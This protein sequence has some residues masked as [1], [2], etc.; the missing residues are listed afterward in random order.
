[1]TDDYLNELEQF[2][3]EFADEYEI[4]QQESPFPIAEKL[5]QFLLQQAILPAHSFLDLAGGSG[6]Y[7]A[8]FQDT[9]EH[10]TLV[11]ISNEML[12]IAKTKLQDSDAA[13]VH[14]DQERFFQSATE[15]FDVVFTAMNPVLL[16]KE[17]LLA[18]TAQSHRW[19]LI[20]RLVQQTDNIF[21]PYEETDTKPNLM[22]NYK[23][24]L[25][26]SG[27]SYNSQDFTF[28]YSEEV[29]RDFFEA[30]FEKELSLK[31]INQIVE[32]I[33]GLSETQLN[34]QTVCYQLIY[35]LVPDSPLVKN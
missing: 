33:F 11:D 22:E 28:T 31:K 2:W 6:R 1:M 21:S 16:T 4:I 10:Y 27:I 13:F 34:F 19:C 29:T 7:L 15:T 25:K 30:Y 9:V 17:N 23:Q 35:Y 26:E 24:I 20:F 5:K 3:D 14:Q 8:E 32:K 12:G 18:F